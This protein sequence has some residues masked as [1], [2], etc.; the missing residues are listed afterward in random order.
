MFQLICSF[1]VMGSFAFKNQ[2]DQVGIS[3]E[4][5]DVLKTS[6]LYQFPE[7]VANIPSNDSNN[8]EYKLGRIIQG[9]AD[10]LQIL[11]TIVPHAPENT[12]YINYQLLITLL[13]FQRYWIHF[14]KF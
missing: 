6:L 3:K 11:E 12:I 10:L 14:R 2:I 5:I 1:I 9:A 8:I 13:S 7:D 4:L